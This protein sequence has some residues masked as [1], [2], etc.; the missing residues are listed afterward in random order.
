[1]KN[2]PFTYEE[3][4][5]IAED[6][7][8]LLDTS[9][10]TADGLFLTIDAVAVCPFH[11]DDR[12]DFVSACQN[13]GDPAVVLKSY[14]GEDYDVAVLASGNSDGTVFADFDIRTFAEMQGIV[15]GFPR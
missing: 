6:F 8:D 14:M 10:K 2:S 1:M 13:N 9:F 4:I 7:E 12:R 5:E 11:T 3:A 15:Y